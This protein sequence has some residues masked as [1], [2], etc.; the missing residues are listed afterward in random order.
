MSQLQ[1]GFT[2]IELMMVVAIIGILAAVALPAY[3]E[4][5]IRARITEGLNLAVEA[6][7]AV[8]ADGFASAADL[9]LSSAAWNA[10]AG[11]TGA[12][13]KY[14]RS[15]LLNTDVPPT[16]QITVT[17][18]PVTVG[19]GASNNV[20]ILSPYVRTTA[21][22]AVTLK[23]AQLSGSTGSIDWACTSQTSSMATSGGLL[24]A[25]LGTIP[26]KLMPSQCR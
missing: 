26:A 9:A 5:T 2:L 12:N 23:A 25:P 16:G 20:F 8:A 1:K 18:N 21:G 17:M 24:A 22:T 3:Q 19:L 15:I 14:V 6:K 13:S 7:V 11:S 4:Y 10:R